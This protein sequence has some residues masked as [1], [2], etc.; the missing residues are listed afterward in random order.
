MRTPSLCSEIVSA[1]II[2]RTIAAAIMLAV[3]LGVAGWARWL[4]E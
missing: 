4:A 2:V 3:A 1:L